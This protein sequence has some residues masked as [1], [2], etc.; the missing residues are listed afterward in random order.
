[1]TPL[2]LELF[3]I[4]Y[5][6]TE[7]GRHR[8]TCLTFSGFGEGAGRTCHVVVPSGRPEHITA[9]CVLIRGNQSRH[10][11]V[12]DVR[13]QAREVICG[14]WQDSDTDMPGAE[15]QSARLSEQAA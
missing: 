1:M 7:A 5:L 11:L 6:P 15:Q 14:P 3:D 8:Q 2:Q 12:P 10:G 9:H 4:A 13:V